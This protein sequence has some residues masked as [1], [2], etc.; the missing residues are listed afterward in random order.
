MI[1][2]KKT[3]LTSKISGL[4]TTSALTAVENDLVKK[5]GY[6]TKISDIEK[7][8]TDHNHD[9][10]ITTREFNA[11]T[12]NVFNAKLALA[13]LIKLTE[14]DA[15]FKKISDR[16]TSNK[17]KHLLVENELK[18]L[19]T[20]DL[21]YFR[22]KNCFGG[23]H[24]TQNLLVFQEKEKYFKDE[25][26]SKRYSIR[27]WKS[28]GLSEQ[29]LSISDVVGTINNIKISK[30]I[31]PAYVIFNHKRS[32]FEQKKEDVINSGSIVNIY[33]VYSVSLKTISSNNALKNCL[34]GATKVTKP[35]DATDPHKYILSEQ[36]CRTKYMQQTNHKTF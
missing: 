5:T 8:T 11:M 6:N 24:G 10:Y 18:K 32:Y 26:N 4:A 35:N 9:K 3:D 31:R 30:P 29:S 13:N 22:G 33:I 28:K 14:F 19:K 2:L 23:N 36:I 25:Y 1:R 20:F 12:A 34:F 15:N 7:K 16:L 27:T 21:S 17:N